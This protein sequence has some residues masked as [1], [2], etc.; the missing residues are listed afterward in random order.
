MLLERASD[1]SKERASQITT[2][3]ASR[4]ESGDDETDGDGEFA[5]IILIPESTAGVHTVTVIVD[6]TE[7]EAEFTVEPE[8]I[9]DPTSGEA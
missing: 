8:I 6:G 7:V 5:S 2:I 3:P 4:I 9:I 1:F